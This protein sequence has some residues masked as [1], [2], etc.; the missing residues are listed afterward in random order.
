MFSPYTD[1][2]I[3][4]ANSSSIFRQILPNLMVLSTSNFFQVSNLFVPSPLR[5]GCPSPSQITPVSEQ[6]LIL[7]TEVKKVIEYLSLFCSIVTRVSSPPVD[8]PM[9]FL[10]LLWNQHSHRV[11]LVPISAPRQSQLQ[12]GF[13]LPDLDT[14]YSTLLYT[15]CPCFYLLSTPFLC[16]SSTRSSLSSH[17]G[18]LMKFPVFPHDK[19]VHCWAL[20][21]LLLETS[22]L[23][24]A[25]FPFMAAPQGIRPGNPWTS[26]CLLPW[27]LGSSAPL[28]AFLRTPTSSILWLLQPGLPCVT[29]AATSSPCLWASGIYF[30]EDPSPMQSRS[31]LGFLPDPVLPS[32]QASGWLNPH[33]KDDSLQAGAC[34]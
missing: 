22:Q 23:S 16:A 20:S 13:G 5:Q 14:K 24:R 17:A 18:L 34:Y 19:M 31:I 27:S 10:N 26:L 4:L 6:P 21:K 25:P 29:R 28:P 12:L 2:T 32:Q 7:K 9:L 3:T 33:P 15:A 11:H 1:P 8:G 30:H